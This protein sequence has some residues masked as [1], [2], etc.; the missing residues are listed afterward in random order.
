M[1]V[2]ELRLDALAVT[3]G[4]WQ[5]SIIVRLKGLD[6]DP[7]IDLTPDE[8]LPLGEWLLT[9]ANERG[10]AHQTIDGRKIGF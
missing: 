10:A 8:G 3:A 1:D 7:F 2:D 4:A 9:R 5:I 6:P